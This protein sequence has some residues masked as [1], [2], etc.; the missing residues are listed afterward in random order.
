[1]S[2]HQEVP[3]WPEEQPYLHLTL[4]CMHCRF[5]QD[6]LVNAYESICNSTTALTRPLAMVNESLQYMNLPHPAFG[7]CH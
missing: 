6:H 2:N 5:Y 1:M 7:K 4:T 3:L